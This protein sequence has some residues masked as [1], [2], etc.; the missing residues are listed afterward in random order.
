MLVTPK[1]TASTIS[2][3][4]AVTRF[5]E[6]WRSVYRL[7]KSHG[8]IKV[9]HEWKCSEDL[10]SFEVA[11]WPFPNQDDWH[12][13]IRGWVWNCDA[14]SHPCLGKQILRIL[15]R[16]CLFPMDFFQRNYTASVRAV[17]QRFLLGNSRLITSS[18]WL[19]WHFFWHAHW[20]WRG[21]YCKRLTSHYVY[22]PG[23][24]ILARGWGERK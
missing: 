14:C 7:A 6:F 1:S 12:A 22:E 16:T 3:E 24:D 13:A 19:L 17:C 11:R 18:F 15:G 20:R 10:W 2:T 9:E 23:K 5:E 4:G 8:G 21:K